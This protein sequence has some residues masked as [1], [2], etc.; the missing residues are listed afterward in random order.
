MNYEIQCNDFFLVASI[1]LGD[2]TAM[3]TN[4]M[5][6]GAFE[7]NRNGLIR[8]VYNFRQISRIFLYYFLKQL[9]FVTA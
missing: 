4:Y 3:E 9:L 5:R 6:N 2:K 1:G 8:L 7:Q